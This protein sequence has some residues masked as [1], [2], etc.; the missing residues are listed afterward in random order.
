MFD[1]SRAA[2]F[3]R[4]DFAYAMLRRRHL[5]LMLFA[6]MPRAALRTCLLICHVAAMPRLFFERA[7]CCDSALREHAVKRAQHKFYAHAVKKE[8]HGVYV[9]ARLICHEQ[10]V[11]FK[12][13]Q[14]RRYER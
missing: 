2:V 14:Q 5:S 12:D 13:A 7:L 1:E 10:R 8:R 6:I 11:A 4:H 9:Y 3:I